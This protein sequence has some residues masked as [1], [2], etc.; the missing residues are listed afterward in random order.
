[1][2][3]SGTITGNGTIPLVIPVGKYIR[4]AEIVGITGYIA[5]SATSTQVSS[6]AFVTELTLDAFGAEIE[7]E[8]AYASGGSEF[9]ITL[10]SLDSESVFDEATLRVALDP[11]TCLIC[12]E[13]LDIELR[14]TFA[15]FERTR[16]ELGFDFEDGFSGFEFDTD[17]VP[18]GLSWLSIDLS[19]DFSVTAKDVDVT[20]SLELEEFGCVTPYFTIDLG[21]ETWE[22]DGLTLYGLRLRYGMNGVTVESLTYLDDIHHTKEDY[23]EMFRIRVD[24]DMCCGGGFDFE[25][26]THFSKD[27][28][29][30]FDWAETELELE[31]DWGTHTTFGGYVSFVTSGLSELILNIEVTW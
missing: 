1:M 25:T 28:M 14:P 8:F 6:E 16:L 20:P 5:D 22:L 12:F 19:I 4:Y 17:G 13:T 18:T 31:L 10:G 30:L 2:W 15:C 21:T 23:W 11:V 29:T 27:H 9:S 7:A 24:G 26:S 3:V